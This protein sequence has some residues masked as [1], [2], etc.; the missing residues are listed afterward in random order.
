VPF[1]AQTY[2]FLEAFPLNK[3]AIHPVKR[4]SMSLWLGAACCRRYFYTASQPKPTALR[5]P[6]GPFYRQEPQPNRSWFQKRIQHHNN[7]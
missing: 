7:Y 3:A 5:K 2:V 6:T 1:G 4:Q